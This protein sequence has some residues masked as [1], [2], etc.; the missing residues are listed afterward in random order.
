MLGRALLNVAVSDSD[1]VG[2][3]PKATGISRF[4]HKNNSSAI[5]AQHP[6][7]RWNLEIMWDSDLNKC[8]SKKHI[9][10]KMYLSFREPLDLKFFRQIEGKVTVTFRLS[11]RKVC[12]TCFCWSH[13]MP[14]FAADNSNVCCS[15]HIENSMLIDG[16]TSGLI[17]NTHI[18]H[19]L[20]SWKCNAH[21]TF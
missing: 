6:Q 10:A 9:L 21:C 19:I 11:V 2:K 1:R 13:Y 17:C 3:I 16:F 15:Q 7:S 12:R 4:V 8:Q 5:I 18:S 14:M 20:N